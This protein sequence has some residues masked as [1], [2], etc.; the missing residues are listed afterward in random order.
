MRLLI[1]NYEYPPLGG[2]A[3]RCT[4]YQAE[5][6]ASLGHDVTVITTWFE[7]E[8]ELEEYDHLKLI[9]LKSWR[10]KA[11]RSNPFEMFS[12]AVKTFRFIRRTKLY[13]Q[14]DLILTHFTIPGGMVSLPMNLLYKTPY[15]IISHGQDIP[16]F[17]PK[18]LFL[19]H[20]AFYLPIKWIC[21]RASKITV[22]SQQRLNEL[23]RVTGPKQ[24]STNL[25]IPNG[26]DIAFFIPSEK[27]KEKE[28]LRLLFVGR[29]TVQK[30]P[31]TL[32][33]ALDFLSAT[34]TPFSMEIV[35]DGP[36][37]RK[38]ESFVK[39]HELDK[40]VS[41]YGWVSR[42]ELREK[43]KSAHLLTITSSDEGQSLAMME[44]ISS[45]LYLFTTPVSGSEFLIRENVNGNFIPFGK[46]RLIAKHLETFYKE[47]VVENYKVPAGVLQELRETISWA[48]YVHAYDR[49]IQQ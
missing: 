48:H 24:S 29:L 34:Q 35:G 20:L 31:F 18:E 12:W 47:K 26:C 39:A 21:S 28:K 10:R 13:L 3:G 23:N 2:G 16:W 30:D 37:R 43:Y 33:K 11:Y 1:L 17:S 5:G 36:L 6:L 32:L 40:W 41:F 8:K 9:R 19:Y 15:Y 44:A 38:M 27:D 49:I 14:T 4:K 25:I 7:G 46:P 45:G 22:L 42:E